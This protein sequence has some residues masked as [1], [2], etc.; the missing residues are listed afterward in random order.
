MKRLEIAVEKN[1][2]VISI[3]TV[4]HLYGC[5][6]T[7][8]CLIYYGFQNINVIR[9]T[10]FH[11]IKHQNW[12]LLL[13]IDLPVLPTRYCR[14]FFVLMIGSLCSAGW[15]GLGLQLLWFLNIERLCNCILQ[16]LFPLLHNLYMYFPYQIWCGCTCFLSLPLFILSFLSLSFL[17]FTRLTLSRK[18][19]P[20]KPGPAHGFSLLKGSFSLPLC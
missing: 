3:I 9:N 19:P 7:V 4:N 6:Q 18:V 15:K 20:C 13:N 17:S 16:Y 10:I 14:F 1:G 8:S 11:I 2:F 5:S 12:F